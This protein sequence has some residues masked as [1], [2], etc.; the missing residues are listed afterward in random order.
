MKMMLVLTVVLLG[1]SSYAD[2]PLLQRTIRTISNGGQIQTQTRCKI[3]KNRVRIEQT[4]KAGEHLGASGWE[5]KLIGSVEERP[6]SLV[7]I[8]TFAELIPEAGRAEFISIF[9]K[10]EPGTSKFYLAND[11]TAAEPPRVVLLF[12]RGAGR[13]IGRASDQLMA[14][15]D[16]QCGLLS[17]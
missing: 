2:F 15:I 8:S 13:T 14:F 12:E 1:G 7:E 5:E 9:D 17:L 11:E 4:V 6:I 10:T 3:Y 16:I